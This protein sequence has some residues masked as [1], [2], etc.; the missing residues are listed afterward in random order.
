LKMLSAMIIAIIFALAIYFMF[1]PD[2]CRPLEL[3]VFYLLFYSLSVYQLI[4][5]RK[6]AINSLSLPS[7][8]YIKHYEV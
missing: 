8:I 5:W 3:L 2:L 6:R 4:P 1:G 7:H